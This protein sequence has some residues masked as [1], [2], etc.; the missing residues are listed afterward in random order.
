M[1]NQRRALG[2]VAGDLVVGVGQSAHRVHGANGDHEG[3][4]ARSVDRRVTLGAV[5]VVAPVVP[6]GDHDDDSGIPGLLHRLAQGIHRVALKNWTAERKIDY[7][8]IV[9]VLER[10]GALNRGNDGAIG[11]R[12][13]VIQSPKTDNIHIRRDSADRVIKVRT[14]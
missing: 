4:V 12:S 3:A 8:N 10:D 5:G 7:A 9:L 1:V 14:S 2:T 11:R 6:C 13:V